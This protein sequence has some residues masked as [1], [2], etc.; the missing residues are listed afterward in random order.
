M[1]AHRANIKTVVLPEGN[2][3]DI[4]EVPEETKAALEF[5]F[6]ERV[7]DV[8]K[9]ALIPLLIS[10]DH[11]DRKYDEAEFRADR[12]REIE[13]HQEKGERAERR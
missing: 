6:A 13:R 12:E 2:R 4:Q 9:L 8:W 1:A 10:R 3:K 7:E 5:V 11:H